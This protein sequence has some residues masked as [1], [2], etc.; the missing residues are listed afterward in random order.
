MAAFG[1]SGAGGIVLA[2][3]LTAIVGGIQAHPRDICLAVTAIEA[4]R[5]I[6]EADPTPRV[7]DAALEAGVHTVAIGVSSELPGAMD[8]QGSRLGGACLDVLAILCVGEIGRE[9]VSLEGGIEAATY[10]LAEL[11]QSSSSI[12]EEEEAEED[13]AAGSSDVGPKAL[14]LLDR[15]L[16]NETSK[17]PE[18]GSLARMVRAVA[19][20]AIKAASDALDRNAALSRQQGPPSMLLVSTL[21]RC[22]RVLEAL[23]GTK[24]SSHQLVGESYGTGSLVRGMA[25]CKLWQ[26]GAAADG[27]SSSM[28]LPSEAMLAACCA[29]SAITRHHGAA[30]VIEYGGHKAV[31]EAMSRANTGTG[32]DRLLQVEACKTLALLAEPL[33]P[34]GAVGAVVYSLDGAVSGAMKEA[35]AVSA[36]SRSLRENLKDMEIQVAG[37][38]ALRSLCAL[39]GGEDTFVSEAWEAGGLHAA[40]Q[41][42]KHN[43]TVRSLQEAG[44]MLLDTIQSPAISADLFSSGGGCGALLSAM[45]SHPSSDPLIQGAAIATLS[46]RA[47]SANG[48]ASVAIIL[49]SRAHVPVLEAMASLP[50][51]SIIQLNGVALLHALAT[52]RSTPGGGDSAISGT[53]EAAMVDCLLLAMGRHLQDR[54]IQYHGCHA[55]SRL[56]KSVPDMV[57]SGP[58]EGGDL[59]GTVVASGPSRAESVLSA[60]ATAMEGHPEDEK[61]QAGGVATL[62]GL[63]VE[64][65]GSTGG[66]RGLHQAVI[67][68]MGMHPSCL[69]IQRDG[70]GSL[71]NLSQHGGPLARGDIL[72]AKGHLAILQAMANFG[73]DQVTQVYATGALVQLS[74]DKDPAGGASR[75][76]FDAGAVKAT[77]GALESHGLNPTV[78]HHALWIISRLAGAGRKAPSL[79]SAGAPRAVVVSM[80]KHRSHVCVQYYGIGACMNMAIGGDNDTVA[81]LVDQGVVAATIEAMKMYR[82]VRELQQ[83][84][85]NA[86]GN[87]A[88]QGGSHEAHLHHLVQAGALD[89]IV[90][91]MAAH[92][93]DISTQHAGSCALKAFCVS[94]KCAAL[95]LRSGG[96][97]ASLNTIALNEA[98][99]ATLHIAL[100]VIARLCATPQGG[101]AV[102]RAGGARSILRL[103]RS[104]PN[105]AQIQTYGLRA[106][107]S[108]AITSQ[109]LATSD[110]REGIE[111]GFESLHK[112][113]SST[114]VCEAGLGVLGRFAAGD[115]TI[116]AGDSE[117]DAVVRAMKTHVNYPGLQTSSCLLLASLAT[118][119]SLSAIMV[120][121]G[122][123]EAVAETASTH[124]DDPQVIEAVCIL[125]E[126]I[127]ASGPEGTR[128]LK[129]A[130]NTIGAAFDAAETLACR[131]SI[132]HYR[133]L[134]TQHL[135]R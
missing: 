3:G 25:L 50:D 103:L 57:A 72:A 98:S 96:L 38:T 56:C 134:I 113:A 116:P 127:A 6:L 68:A 59:G 14:L 99:P 15:I 55:L 64:A 80:R 135:E 118:R 88:T 16:A 114:N 32:R 9:A 104:H 75:I 29:L 60:V 2:G 28:S 102:S 33:A 73:A 128:A 36:V 79:V 115:Q 101:A 52:C 111:A 47:W 58:D 89:A 131:P 125:L 129:E 65:G 122:V 130:G 49:A 46:H 61:L 100:G 35:Q 112:H 48:G 53:T 133:S 119:A 121:R 8:V 70:C 105:K 74:L 82:D 62:M 42:M 5:A 81:A 95:S 66:R 86:L 12:Q 19:C 41:G 76:L 27:S 34:V 22:G 126:R 44:M 30:M 4:L 97:E 110:V 11:N 1:P 20:G 45:S 107:E 21:W 83:W 17:D 24:E 123:C 18:G 7:V 10:I 71:S 109:N 91:A 117:I 77:L 93:C 124:S 84:G 51:D 54:G 23:S 132:Q 92:P 94:P 120:E 39:G 13:I 37:V 26:G 69:A 87:L 67:A 108:M 90:L 78:C 85:C 40:V 43:R 31:V 63:A 106:L